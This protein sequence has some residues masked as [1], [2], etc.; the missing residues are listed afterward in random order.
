MPP[1]DH[2]RPARLPDRCRVRRSK[3][4]LAAD[5]SA[6]ARADGD[7][8]RQDLHRLHVQPSAARTRRVQAHSLPGR[9]RQPRAPDARRISRLPAR[10]AQAARSP[11][12]T[13]SSKLGRRGPRQG[14]ASVVIS[15]IQRVY[16]MLTGKRTCRRKTRR[17]RRFEGGAS[18]A[19]R[20]VPY[21]RVDAD[22]E[23]RP[24]HHRR[25]PPLDLRHLAAGA[26]LFR[27]L[28]RR[29]HRDAVTP[30]ARFFR[31]EPR[32]PISL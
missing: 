1:L 22:R 11:N 7:R 12:S 19:E 20:I 21:N 32:R 16:S 23:L 27:R 5:K 26:R 4:P 24:R 10:R 31:Q 17:L 13:T 6:R 18:E 28:H 29:P 30:H 3:F 25:M 9:P 14:C 8:R 2:R 15:T